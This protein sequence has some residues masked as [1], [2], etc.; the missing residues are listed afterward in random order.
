MPDQVKQRYLLVR[1][2]WHKLANRATIHSVSD[3]TI[4]RLDEIHAIWLKQC[5]HE[6]NL[7]GEKSLTM[8]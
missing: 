4:L 2:C 6:P 3:N 5:L 7:F 1:S 8:G